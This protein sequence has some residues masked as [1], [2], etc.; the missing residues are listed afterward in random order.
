[1]YSLASYMTDEDIQNGILYPS[2]NR[3]YPCLFLVLNMFHLP[4]FLVFF[5]PDILLTTKRITYQGK[6]NPKGE[7]MFNF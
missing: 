1:M 5:S 4:S 3:Y 6:K 7:L 2:I